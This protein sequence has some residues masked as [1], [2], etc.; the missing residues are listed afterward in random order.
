MIGL[1]IASWL[2][3]F[4]EYSL[5]VPAKDWL[6]RQGAFYATKSNSGSDHLA[7]FHGFYPDIL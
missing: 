7:G 1:I 4:L 3:A 2:I 5:M 6:Q